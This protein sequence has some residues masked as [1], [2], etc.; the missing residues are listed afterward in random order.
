MSIEQ[1]PQGQD[2]ARSRTIIASGNANTAVASDYFSEPRG[3]G[4]PAK[5][6]DAN[7]PDASAK[8][9]GKPPAKKPAATTPAS[10]PGK[11]E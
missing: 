10:K 1:W 7:P 11:G 2:S 6:T 9:H 5:A 3:A 8:P 4:L